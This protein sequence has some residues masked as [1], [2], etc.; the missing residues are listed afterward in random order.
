[1]FPFLVTRS[2]WVLVAYFATGNYL[3]NPSYITYVKRGYFLTRV[4]PLDIFARWDSRWYFSIIKDGYQASV[5][6]KTAYSNMAFFPLYPY[7]VKSLGW[8][9][10]DLPNGYYILVGLILSNLCF[11]ASAMLLYKL[12]IGPLGFRHATA[13]RTLG[14]LL[15]FPASFFFASFYPE[16][17]FLFLTLAAFTLALQEKWLLTGVCTALAIL[18]RPQGVVLAFALAWLYMEQ[19]HWRLQDIRPNVLWFALTPLAL[20]LHFYSL[21]L[22]SGDFLAYFDATKAWGGVD[23]GIFQNPLQNLQGP[24]LDVFKIDFILIILF[25]ICSIYMLWKWPVKAY[26]IFA[27]IMCIMP[28][29]TGLLVSMSRELVVIFPIFILLGEKLKRREGYLFLQAAWFALQIIYFAGWVNYYW[30]A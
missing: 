12:I 23:A 2:I 21:Y 8:F 24:S 20:L 3:S 22:K 11:L 27:L 9:G 15:V 4:F 30:I 29:A 10:L 14:L 25:L 6:L 7:L 19:R 16:S 26:G 17:L 5:N 18:A 13:Q 28:L 1:M